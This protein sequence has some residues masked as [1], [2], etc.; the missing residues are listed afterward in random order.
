MRSFKSDAEGAYE[1]GLDHAGAYQA[2]VGT[3]AA[4]GAPAGRSTVKVV[5][6]DQPE[7]D[8][9]IVL[10]ANSISGRVTDPDGKGIR[11]VTVTASRE[12]GG[13]GDPARSATAPTGADG[14]Y[15]LDAV[16]VG[17]YRVMARGTGYRAAD[18]YPV[19]VSDDT[20][21]PT[22]DLTLERGWILK[23]RVVDPDGRPLNGAMIIIAAPGQAE[24]GA[25]S[26]NSDASGTFRITAPAEG[27]MSVTA[28]ANGFAPAVQDAVQPPATPDD[29]PTVLRAGPGGALRIR[30]VDAGGAPLPGVRVALRPDPLYPGWDAIAQRAPNPPTGPDGT[31][32]VTLLAPREY[33]VT[34]P[35]QKGVEPVIVSVVEGTEALA[36]ITVP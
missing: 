2:S 22:A 17:T 6:P 32:I 30:A 15:R 10:Q 19:V 25:L 27:P 35:G 24:S 29:P 5:V 8:Q 13:S 20:P 21:N 34:V 18:A 31:A 11:G 16:D 9:D 3:T 23:G 1:V 28:L 14:S 33:V 12:S 26:T 4:G 7:V 36:S